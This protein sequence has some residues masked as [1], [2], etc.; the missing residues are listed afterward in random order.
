M[1]K[2]TSV[3]AALSFAKP[4][5]PSDMLVPCRSMAESVLPGLSYSLNEADMTGSSQTRRKATLMTH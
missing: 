4:M 5:I 3:M 2:D 1:S